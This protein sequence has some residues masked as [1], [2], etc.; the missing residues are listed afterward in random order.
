[1][2]KFTTREYQ[3]KA[4]NKAIDYL[5]RYKS[6]L[7]V[8]PTGAGKTLMATSIANKVSKKK[9]LYIS[10]RKELLNQ[11]KALKNIDV[12]SDY[13]NVQSSHKAI[14]EYDFIVIDEA[15]HI[16]AS[17]YVN[18]LKRYKNAK[19][20]GITATPRRLDGKSIINIFDKVVETSGIRTLQT[21]GFLVPAVEYSVGE[22]I[23]LRELKIT[24]G[25]YNLKEL[26]IKIRKTILLGDV[27]KEFDLHAKTKQ[28]LVYCVDVAHSK[29][30]SEMFSNNGYSS[31]AVYGQM[32]SIDRESAIN[33]FKMNKVQVMVNCMLFTEGIDLPNVECVIMLRPTLS[34]ALYLQMIGRG[35]RIYDN[36]EECI[37]LDHTN[38]YVTHG[39]VNIDIQWY[40]KTRER[41]VSGNPDR[42]AIPSIL[43]EI[44]Y[45]EHFSLKTNYEPLPLFSI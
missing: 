45:L 33:D 40:R 30:V 20:L 26:G 22:K 24:G 32:K 27:L 23:D 7:L 12:V 9:T 14:V 13:M 21:Q 25:D 29:E 5:E 19:I 28:T 1:M 10:H 2:D 34:Y 17:S 39:T 41:V 8:S 3:D 15:H 18:L 11:F 31:V 37:M 42:A 36:K 4:I 35:L 38:N 16:V 43:R 44:E 6:V